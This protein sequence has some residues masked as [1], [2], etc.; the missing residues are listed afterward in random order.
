MTRTG[1]Q[2]IEKGSLIEIV[3]RLKA[4]VGLCFSSTVM[5]ENILQAYQ[6]AV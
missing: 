4:Y 1:N 5:Q 3:V 6:V 2:H